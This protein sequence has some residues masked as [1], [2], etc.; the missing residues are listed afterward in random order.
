[1]ETA[2]R[3]MISGPTKKTGSTLIFLNGPAIRDMFEDPMQWLVIGA[4]LV[5]ILLWGPKKI[6]ELARSVGR[7]KKEFETAKKEFQNPTDTLLTAPTA[8]QAPVQ[9]SGD[10][11]LLET[12]RKVGVVTEGKTRSQV[13]DEILAK[14][15]EQG[16][17]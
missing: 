17:T 6:P 4:V 10:D 11:T 9:K 5:V 15:R 7:A 16:S 2:A 1:M 13:S 3:L 14:A 8:S 12:A